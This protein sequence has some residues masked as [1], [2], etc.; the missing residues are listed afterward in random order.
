[1]N[2]KRIIE[3]ELEPTLFSLGY[4]RGNWGQG[5]YQYKNDEAG[6]SI[7]YH[8]AR[9]GQQ[10]TRGIEVDFHVYSLAGKWFSLSDFPGESPIYYDTQ[11]E[12]DHKLRHAFDATV[13]IVLPYIQDMKKYAVPDP[14]SEDYQ[15]LAN[16]PMQRAERFSS[17]YHIPMIPERTTLMQLNSI[18][19]SIRPTNLSELRDSFRA[20]YETLINMAAFY[21]TLFVKKAPRFCWGWAPLIPPDDPIYPLIT[22]ETERF[23]IL[24]VG[25]PDFGP[26]ERIDALSFSVQ[27]WNYVETKRNQFT[28]VAL[29]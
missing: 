19:K 1:M 4:K 2:L 27:V 23:V 29:M 5:W 14:C 24:E 3:T 20:N 9:V 10:F 25:N 6:I 12:L 17:Q 22:P 8:V 11:A 7:E 16:C 18:L 28:S 26:S 15:A 13:N 21:G